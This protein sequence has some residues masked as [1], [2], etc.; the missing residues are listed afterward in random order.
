MLLLVCIYVVVAG[1]DDVTLGVD[2]I[3]VADCDV[4]RS[5]SAVVR[6]DAIGVIVV[7]CVGIVGVGGV[8]VGIVAGVVGV[9]GV[10]NA[11]CCSYI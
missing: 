10:W 11:I 7:I 1:A 3:G 4:V 9:G 5:V 6:C 2:I 8:C